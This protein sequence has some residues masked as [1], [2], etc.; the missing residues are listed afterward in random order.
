MGRVMKSIMFGGAVVWLLIIPLSVGPVWGATYYMRADGKAAKKAATS[1]SSASSA[2][3]VATHNAATFSPDDVI[4]LCDNGGDYKSSI[5]A[6]SNGTDGHPIT[7]R[8]AEGERPT[9]DLSVDVGGTSGWAAMG[10]GVY[11][12]SGSARV[13]WEDDV[14]LRAASSTACTNG[15]W[16]YPN[17]SL[18]LYYKPTSGTP[19]NHLIRTMWFDA[20]TNAID[21]RNRSNITV[22]GL[23]INRSGYGV[24]HG[25]NTSS[26]VSSIRNIIL[27]DN[28]FTRTYWAIYSDAVKNGIESNVS[29][30][31]NIVDY[32]NSGISAWTGSDQTP[33]HSQHHSRY[34]ITKNRITNLYSISDTKVWSDA[35]LTSYYY[36]DHEGISFQDVQDSVISD[37]IITNTFAKD[38]TSDEY[39]NRAVYLYLTNGNSATSGNSILRNYISGHFVPAV[40]INADK[41]FRGFENNVI[42]YNVIYYGLPNKDHTSFMVRATSDNLLPG[43]NY[44]INNTIYNASVGLGISVPYHRA[45]K[46]VFRNNIVKSPSH[47]N[48]SS[49]EETGDLTFDH[50]IYDTSTS[51]QVGNAGMTF[52][53]WR[54]GKGYDRAGSRIADPLFVS[55]GKDFH[56]RSGS[57]AIKS[58]DPIQFLKS[59]DGTAIPGIP[60]IG[61]Y[62]FKSSLTAPTSS[63]TAQ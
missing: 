45:G 51:F 54:N 47:V 56:L 1:C 57:P 33:G 6:P 61:A 25:N 42:A 55:P 24:K 26:P 15:N 53:E 21:L 49:D 20:N 40:Y 27:H 59:H 18:Q 12:K 8:N 23:T 13:L 35:L 36:N 19:A 29:I 9:I 16:Y 43:T 44:F 58:G 32:C 34:S 2:M 41:G 39:W 28:T 60:D 46:W 48:I 3:S 17:G 7:Y 52:I 31:N 14:P 5:I 10:G 62:E 63:R 22:Y 4:C 30:Y 37:N 11:R 38:M 50:N